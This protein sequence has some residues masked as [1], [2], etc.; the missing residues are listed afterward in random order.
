MS[1]ETYNWHTRR[2]DESA[3]LQRQR[4][5]TGTET[6]ATNELGCIWLVAGGG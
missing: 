2:T 6:F 3:K 5:S 4:P 1:K